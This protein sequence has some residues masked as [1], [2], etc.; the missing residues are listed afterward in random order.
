[1]TDF[2]KGRIRSQQ[3]GLPPPIGDPTSLGYM[4][5]EGNKRRDREPQAPRQ[6]WEVS[7]Y[8]GA[9]LGTPIVVAVI[10]GVVALLQE[11]DYVRWGLISGG[12]VFAV[13][14]VLGLL[15]VA[16]RALVVVAPLLILGAAALYLL[17]RIGVGPGL[18]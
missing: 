14:L 9:L 17:D 18:P 4:I 10:V 5:E 11:G 1:M 3:G 13:I 6:R 16:I 7:E 12:A 8:F 2:E 15:S